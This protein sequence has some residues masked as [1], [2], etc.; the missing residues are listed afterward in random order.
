MSKYVRWYNDRKDF[1]LTFAT[2]WASWAEGADLTATEA[3]GMTKFFRPIA[4]RFGLVQEFNE[5]GVLGY[6]K[7]S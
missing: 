5:L 3:E 2:R 1:Y 7:I 4:R 6:E